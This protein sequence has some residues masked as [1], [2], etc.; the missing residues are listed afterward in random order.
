MS[1]WVEVR[2]VGKKE[3]NLVGRVILEGAQ[4]LSCYRTGL[5]GSPGTQRPSHN[6]R[7]LRLEGLPDPKTPPTSTGLL[8]SL[9]IAFPAN[10]THHVPRAKTIESKRCQ[11]STL[12]RLVLYRIV[13][14]ST[15]SQ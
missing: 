12:F 13:Y 3:K 10:G 15:V 6:N 9:V 8:P 11:K 1:S 4:H 5:L 2:W 14:H 7:M